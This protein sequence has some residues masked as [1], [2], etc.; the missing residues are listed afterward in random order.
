MTNKKIQEHPLFVK[1]SKALTELSEEQQSRLL[2]GGHLPKGKES[3]FAAL[4]WCAR[5]SG[6]LEQLRFSAGMLSCY[7]KQTAPFGMT[8][9]AHIQYAVENFYFRYAS[10]QDRAL[11]AVNE[12]FGLGIQ[13]KQC[14]Y[15]NISKHVAVKGSA[16][17]GVLDELWG[18][19][20]KYK[21]DRDDIAHHGNYSDD[22][23]WD[24]GAFCTV[25]KIEP[26]KF[27]RWRHHYKTLADRY[28]IARKQEFDA[29]ILRLERVLYR[30]L[31]VMGAHLDFDAAGDGGGR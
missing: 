4:R 20:Q 30:L 23:L 14:S 3:L 27:G 31:D 24:I 16:I 17:P 7:R 2:R 13:L 18:L 10:A 25:D 5:F 11:R 12:V 29:D 19:V 28:V 26:S 6:F 1:A 8:R 22:P 21:A 15:K 9:H